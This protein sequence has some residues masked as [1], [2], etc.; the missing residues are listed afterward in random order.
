VLTFELL[1][2]KNLNLNYRSPPQLFCSFLNALAAEITRGTL[3]NQ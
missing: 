1:R 2:G 3:G